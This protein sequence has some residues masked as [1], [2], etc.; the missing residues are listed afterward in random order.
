MEND[1]LAL[2]ASWLFTGMSEMVKTCADAAA[3]KNA[4]TA[5]ARAVLM[6]V[7]VMS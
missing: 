2:S 5:P 7:P 6:N 1:G 3:A 4:E